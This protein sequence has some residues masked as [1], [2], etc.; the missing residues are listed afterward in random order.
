MREQGIHTHYLVDVERD[1]FDKVVQLAIV[2]ALDGPEYLFISFDI[3]SLD[4]VYGPR[5]G[6]PETGGFTNREAFPIV[7]RLCAETNFVGMELPEAAPSWD[8][9]C[10]P[11]SQWFTNHYRSIDRSFNPQTGVN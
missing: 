3:D 4:P 11:R 2:Q 6:T 7:R 9:G 8:P 10:P 5:T 1:G